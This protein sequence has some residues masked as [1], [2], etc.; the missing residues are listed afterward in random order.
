[1][2]PY[3]HKQPITDSYVH[4]PYALEKSRCQWKGLQ[5]SGDMQEGSD[6]IS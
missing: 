3:I 4:V 2:V 5:I 6:K 1:M